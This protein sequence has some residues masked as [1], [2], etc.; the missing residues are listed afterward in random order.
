[1]SEPA[2]LTLAALDSGDAGELGADRVV[3]G[4]A[5]SE[6]AGLYAEHDVLLKLSRVESLG[7]P[8]IEAFHVGVPCVV[9]PYTGHEEYVRHGQN[10]IVA[11]FDDLP[12]VS[13]WLDLLAR[14]R[15]LLGRLGEEALLT[16]REWPDS[17][18]AGTEFA[19]AIEGWV[20]DPP[21]GSDQALPQLMADLQ[22]AIALGRQRAL[23]AGWGGE[24]GHS[25]AASRAASFV[26]SKG[27]RAARRAVRGLRR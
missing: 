22:L 14:D 2:T 3:G 23:V 19:D 15:A 17:G 21:V 8:P 26:R 7:L 13:G 9:T 11:G 6:M 18:Q 10:G 5:P 4:L 20:D 16:A 25:P 27:A 1:M 24:L 12:A